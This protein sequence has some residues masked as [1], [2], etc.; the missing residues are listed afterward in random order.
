MQY[1]TA[2][3]LV[4]LV[5]SC[6][7]SPKPTFVFRKPACSQ[8][9]I[10]VDN[11]SAPDRYSSRLG[12]ATLVLQKGIDTVYLHGQ[13]NDYFS[14]Y[15]FHPAPAA[16]LWQ[17][18]VSG[19]HFA[20]QHAELLVVE[21]PVIESA[22]PL[23]FCRASSTSHD[24]LVRGRH[25]LTETKV[26]NGDYRFPHYSTQTRLQ[27]DGAM[28]IAVT[29]QA[30][31]VWSESLLLYNAHDGDCQ[32]EVGDIVML[33]PPTVDWA[34][35]FFIEDTLVVRLSGSGLDVKTTVTLDGLA[36][37]EIR[38]GSNQSIE[39]SFTRPVAGTYSVAIAN[40]DCTVATSPSITVPQDD[41]VDPAE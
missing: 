2:F 36:P 9:R 30:N 6:R 35:A 27:D 20:D 32:A 11:A 29:S 21:P 16:G 17:A 8:G 15:A 37:L 3:S 10:L 34:V 1:L 41:T 33:D 40:A 19:D 4:A 23:V 31:E 14:G 25:L 18:T 22:A 24:I 38:T 26:R 12:D 7:T 39:A 13:E 5:S 28:V